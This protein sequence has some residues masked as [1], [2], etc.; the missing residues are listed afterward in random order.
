M[1]GSEARRLAEAR[2]VHDPVPPV[3][4]PD[5]ATIYVEQGPPPGTDGMG[6]DI[7]IVAVSVATGEARL[8]VDTDWFDGGPQVSP[9]GSMVVY[10]HQN[11]AAGG[12][13][14]IRVIPAA[15][16]E[17]LDLTG[18]PTIN[19]SPT[20]LSDHR[21]MFVGWREG[22]AGSYN[23]YTIAAD[24]SDLSAFLVV[25]D[26]ATD[27]VFPVGHFAPAVSPDREWVAFQSDR[28]GAL[29]LYIA[30][31]DGSE[32]RQI[33]MGSDGTAG[34]PT[35]SPDSAFLVYTSTMTGKQGIWISRIADAATAYLDA[36]G[37][38]VWLR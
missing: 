28:N 38:P 37:W 35:W 29:E 9:D 25:D 36:G 1:D 12:G 34:I 23:L 10:I 6:G 22:N 3:W 18:D 8:L 7:D 27:I 11:P 24:G 5:G 15:G 26:P 4:S 14:S 16:G 21:I 19:S 17:P 31:T 13:I 2:P 33:T 30:R 32:V 20:W